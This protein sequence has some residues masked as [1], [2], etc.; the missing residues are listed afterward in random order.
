[1]NSGAKH[2]S[3]FLAALLLAVFWLPSTAAALSEAEARHLLVRSG[4][5][6][7]V[8][9][10]ETLAPLNRKTAIEKILRTAGTEAVTDP[11]AWVEGWVPPRMKALS[12]EERRALRN[13]NKE[14]GLTLK[15]WWMEEMTNTPT[16][17]TEVMTLFWHNHF[18]SSLR[19]V[20]APVLLYRQNRLLRRHALGNFGDLLH[21]IA[22]D[23]AMLVYLD[24]ARSRKGAA[25]ENF[26]RELFELFTLGEGHY[27]E[28]DVKEAA[29]AFTGRSVERKTGA[30]AF[31]RQWHDAGEKT[32][33]G[34]RGRL[35]GDDVIRILLDH[36]RTAS[37]IVEK[38]WRGFISETPDEDEVARL[39]QVFR[40]T[41]YEIRPLLAALLASDAFWA[42]ENRGRLIKSPIDFVVGT[43]RLFDLPVDRY[44]D[45]ARLS[46]RLGQDLFDPPNVKGWPGGTDWITAASL[47]DR[48]ALAER[49][50]GGSRQAEAQA[51]AIQAGRKLKGS[52]RRAVRFDAWLA[53]LP[54]RWQQAEAVS[55][56]LL[57]VP[58]VDVEILDRRASGAQVRQLLGDPAYQL[59]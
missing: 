46:R 41:G 44:E 19:K 55:L 7:D 50:T 24:G 54:D 27:R 4:F 47:L 34:H 42:P 33:L 25:N 3:K 59:K 48:Q 30:F 56:L 10:I 17:L 15:A 1:M 28:A 36:P 6:A 14:R 22:R 21:A 32:V 12:A 26:P 57:A 58:A 49:I 2:D 31:R 40:E 37:F 29:R 45:L 43:V 20:K 5:S 9:E 18:T 53:E 51:I 16:P 11:P 13:Q 35:E 8:A 38:L 23:P 52:A 39:A